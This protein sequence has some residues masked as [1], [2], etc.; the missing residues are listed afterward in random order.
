MTRPSPSSYRWTLFSHQVD[1]TETKETLPD[2]VV[3]VGEPQ[4][5]QYCDNKVKTSKYEWWNFLP[6]FLLEEFDPKTKFA[7]CYF[8]VVC[9]LQV[10]PQITNTN[11]YPTT[12]IPLLGVLIVAGVLKALEDIERHKADKAANSSLTEILD[13]TS[14]EFVTR[15]WSEVQVGDYVRV[16]SRHVLPADVLIVQVWEPN[17]ELPKGSC[18]VETKSLDGETNLKHRGVLPALLGKVTSEKSLQ[19]LR[20]KVIMEHPNS[21]ID[22]FTG[23]LEISSASLTALDIA[24]PNLTSSSSSPARIPISPGNVILRGCVLRSTDFM[25]G[26]VLNTGHD[27]KIMQSKVASK[28]KSSKLEHLATLQLI[29]VIALLL[30]LCL[31][32]S[33]GQYN[34]NQYWDIRSFWYLDWK[35]SAGANFVTRFFSTLLLHSSFVPVA[36][37]VSMALLRFGQAFFM[38]WDLNMYYEEKDLPMTVRTMNLNEELG[39]ITHIFSDKTGTLTSNNMNFRKASIQGVSYGKGIT[40]IGKA[41]WRLQ[42]KSIPVEMLEA[43]ELASR[44]TTPHVSF[45]CPD[46]DRDYQSN[47]SEALRQGNYMTSDQ[48]KPRINGKT[49]SSGK[50]STTGIEMTASSSNRDTNRRPPSSAVTSP[51]S[52]SLQRE[53]IRDFYRFLSVCHEVIPERLETGDVKL[54]APNPDDEALVCAA[55]YFGYEFKDRRDRFAVI[56]DEEADANIEIEILYT[57]PFTSARKRMSVII[58]DIDHKIKII[59]KGADAMILSRSDPNDVDMIRITSEHVNQYSAEGLRCLMVAMAVIE[60]EN[61]QGWSKHYDEANT[62]LSE[63]EKKKRGEEN[64]IEV[65]EDLIERSLHVIGATGIEDRLQE[66]V[67]ETIET[68]L[69]AGFKVWILTGDKEETAI[70]IGVACNLL[71]PAA[72][73]DHI[74]IN[75]SVAPDVKKAAYILRREIA[76]S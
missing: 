42:G 59:T 61:F 10:V 26:L 3:V 13:R 63:L 28:V 49:H 22:H 68:L 35:A 41:A 66:G 47:F 57:I 27:V 9:G 8:L 38:Q 16:K 11:Q 17:P 60:E 51:S 14:G 32:I 76:V 7:N 4:I 31:C 53:K 70:N 62:D 30:F 67:P 69:A 19:Q 72:Y 64:D 21:L 44:S 1:H 12:L 18:Y 50:L 33:V 75:L 40:E 24:I 20:G 54:S 71:L 46:F 48:D 25:V 36:L 23:V 2:R 65:L 55:A 43:E 29:C 6:K 73:M 39:Q 5:A 58:R 34:F 45:Y 37:Y 15:R 56:Y 74:I 52:V